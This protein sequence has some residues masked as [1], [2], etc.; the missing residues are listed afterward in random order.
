MNTAGQDRRREPR[1][2]VRH[3]GVVEVTLRQPD[4]K[5]SDSV[6]AELQDLSLTG[7]KLLCPKL[8]V[9]RQATELNL[10]CAEPQFDL[11]FS[12]EVCWMKPAANGQWHLGC[13]FVPELPA[14]IMENLLAV[15]VL[16]RRR[17]IRNAHRVPVL[18]RWEVSNAL[19]PAFLWD[20]SEGGFCILSPGKAGRQLTVRGQQQADIEVHAEALWDAETDGGCVA[21]CRFLDHDGYHRMLRLL[22]SEELQRRQAAGSGLL[23]RL[24]GAVG[25]LLGRG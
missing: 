11:N 4:G 7:A 8:L 5:I 21:G 18:A 12:A 10:R 13:S 3:H 24:K 25:T 14:G 2:R 9:Y 1:L 6:Q 16:E 19:L 20:F 22:P 23:G 17:W 15:G